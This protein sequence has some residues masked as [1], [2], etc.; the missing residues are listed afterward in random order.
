MFYCVY[1][2]HIVNILEQKDENKIEF[3]IRK[4]FILKNL[5]QVIKNKF[6]IEELNNLANVYLKKYRY[7]CRFDESI[8]N[9]VE[10]LSRSVMM[11]D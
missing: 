1:K 4:W 10:E 5:D 7:N 3:N 6:T 9:I 11:N 8:D 2:Q